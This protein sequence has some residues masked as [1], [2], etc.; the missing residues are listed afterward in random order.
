MQESNAVSVSNNPVFFGEKNESNGR[1]AVWRG[2]KTIKN[3]KTE[4]KMLP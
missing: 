1:G 2:R 4:N 3:S